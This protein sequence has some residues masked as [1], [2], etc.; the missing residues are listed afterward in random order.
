MEV[1]RDVAAV[2][3]LFVAG[4]FGYRLFTKSC[5]ACEQTLTKWAKVCHHC[6]RRE[7]V[8]SVA[9]DMREPS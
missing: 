2:V 8:K 6:G 4:W 5:W 1:L 7:R 3:G 9:H